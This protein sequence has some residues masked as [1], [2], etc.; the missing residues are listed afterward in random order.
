VKLVLGDSLAIGVLWRGA[1]LWISVP[2]LGFTSIVSILLGLAAYASWYNV[3]L[4]SD[5]GIAIHYPQN[6]QALEPEVSNLSQLT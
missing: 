4:P 3:Q 5:V 1:P 6:F 2:A